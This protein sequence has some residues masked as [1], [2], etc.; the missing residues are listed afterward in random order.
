MMDLDSLTNEVEV[1]ESLKRYFPDLSDE[2]KV[3][4]FAPNQREQ[5]TSAIVEADEKDSLLVIQKVKVK[6]CWVTVG[7]GSVWRFT[8]A[9]AVSATDTP[10]GTD[11][12]PTGAI[13][14]GSL[15]A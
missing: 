7:C 2:I 6:V 4:L 14:V 1:S 10:D 11:Q 9:S 8:T 15:L 13:T 5:R 3:T 12:V